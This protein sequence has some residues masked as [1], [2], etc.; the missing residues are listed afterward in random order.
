MTKVNREQLFCSR[1]GCDRRVQITILPNETREAAI[2]RYRLVDGQCDI[3]SRETLQART[4]KA[5]KRAKRETKAET[6][7]AKKKESAD[8]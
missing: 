2:S 7:A 6:K 5:A 4:E 8:A 3:H 1:E